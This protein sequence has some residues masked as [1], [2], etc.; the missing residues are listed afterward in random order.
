MSLF[1][2]SE[3]IFANDDIFK[4][5]FLATDEKKNWIMSE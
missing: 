3:K 2:R 5:F 1:C 4:H